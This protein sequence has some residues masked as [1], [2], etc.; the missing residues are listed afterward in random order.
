MLVG[1]EHSVRNIAASFN[2]SRWSVEYLF[3]LPCYC[4]RT[5]PG[6]DYQQYLAVISPGSSGNGSRLRRSKQARKL[7][8]AIRI[9]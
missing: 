3:S 5:L 1:P 7:T 8:K 4:T 2:L 6:A 9:D